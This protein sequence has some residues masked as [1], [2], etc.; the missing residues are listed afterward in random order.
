MK[1]SNFFIPH[2]ETH[3]K[4]HLI[5]IPALVTYVI[6]FLMLQLSFSYINKVDPGILGINSSITV[7]DVVNSTNQERAKAGLPPLRENSMLDQA[8]LEK[9]K[10]MFEENYW[11]HY[12]P[13]GKDPWGF[14]QS[15]GYRFSFAGENLA[16]NFYN[17]PDVMAAWMA[18]P[19]HKKNIMHEQ[20]QEIGIA[21]LEG[22][23]N[24]EPTLLVVQEF[25]RPVEAVAQAPKVEVA[26]ASSSQVVPTA[27][28]TSAPIQLSTP[29]PTVVPTLSPSP[30]IIPTLQPTLAAGIKESK[31]QG[32]ILL[33]PYQINR[34]L[35]VFVLGLLAVLLV[36]DLYIIRRRA[37]HRLTSRHLP[38]LAF[39]SV[40]ASTLLSY[41]RGSIM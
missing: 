21:V 41:S 19:T 12:S 32:R 23:L 1:L 24:G 10:N 34:N 26:A 25:G 2:P 27:L 22:T 4:A 11:A 6:L 30:T 31:T 16:R 33:D 9:A 28:P 5:S 29:T 38:H 15:A 37:I 7:G 3:K 8:A 20:Y 13:S 36:A 39:I 35:G 40:A 14:I 17:T 18:S